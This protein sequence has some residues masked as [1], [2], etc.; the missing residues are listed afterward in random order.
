MRSDDLPVH[1]IRELPL[2]GQPAEIPE[3]GIGKPHE[4]ALPAVRP[5]AQGAMRRLRQHLMAWMRPAAWR[6]SVAAAILEGLA[7]E[8]MD[9]VVRAQIVA[10]LGPQPSKLGQVLAQAW[11]QPD[12]ARSH[13]PL[14]LKDL[15][16]GQSL[17]EIVSLGT[18]CFTSG[19]LR[20]WGLRSQSGPFD[21]LFSSAA[22]VAHCLDDDF[23]TFLDPSCY[24]PVPVEQR[25]AGASANRVNHAYYLK[26]FGVEHVFNHHDIHLPEDYEHFQRAV[27][28]FRIGL[29]SSNFRV[30]VL[31]R[32]HNDSF[33][34]E[35]EFVRRA[36]ARRTTNYRLLAYSVRETESPLTPHLTPVL[37]APDA[38]G[39]IFDPVSRWEPL[40][41]PD[42]LDEH[43]L[44]HS[45]LGHCRQGSVT[46]S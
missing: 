31:T 42:L 7:I 8:D 24:V 38:V 5:V 22:M 18:H 2:V 25:K 30:Y 20:K 39:Y 44:V 46:A 6:E 23:A 4:A 28:R 41:F 17:P 27:Q 19:L 9:G 33:L 10:E 32:W 14:L 36:L 16:G 37:D 1:P 40:Q 29:A 12:V 45:I 26:H 11:H 3:I 35:L 15:L 34:Q 21:W 13:V 43:C